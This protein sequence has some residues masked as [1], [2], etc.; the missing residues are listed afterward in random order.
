MREFST[1]ALAPATE[2]EP[3]AA[4]PHRWAAI[5]PE[6][7]V[8]SR[9]VSGHWQPVTAAQFSAEIR[10]TA[11][12]FIAAGIQPGDRVGLWSATRYEWSVLDYALGAVGAVSIPLYETEQ[13][14]EV[15]WILA[16]A[17]SVAL[18]AE[19]S[20]WLDRLAEAGL[21]EGLRVRWSLE[22]GQ[23]SALSAL[24]RLGTAV[25]D[26]AVSDRLAARE[27]GDVATVIYTSGTT[28]RPKG[29]MLTHG[30]VAAATD[31]AVAAEAEL[32]TGPDPATLLF[33]PLAHIFARLIQ[34]GA[35]R[36]GVRLGHSRGVTGLPE[37]L[38]AFDPTF[39][40]GVPRVF[41][42]VYNTASQR[43]V[44]DG[45]GRRFARATTAAIRFSRAL[46]IGRLP[47]PLRAE[48]AAFER[49]VYPGI[50]AAFGERCRFAI[51]GGAPLGERLA[52]FYRGAGLTIL[53]GYGVSEAGGALTANTP[54]S[55]KI[56]T[57][58]RPLPGVAVRVADDGELLFA[59][60]SLF[61]GYVRGGADSPVHLGWLHTGDCGE[62]D[63]EG[64]VRVTGRL[65]ELLVTA[66]GKR[67][68]PTFLEDRLR[69]HHLI[70]QALVVGDG[71]PFVA[72][73]I[74]VDPVEYADWAASRGLPSGVERGRRMPA[75]MAEIQ[76]AVDDANSGV[77]PAESIRGFAVLG[78]TWSEETGE[79]TPSLK[80]R[81]SVILPQ[82]RDDVD[83]LYAR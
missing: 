52:H 39:V 48:H 17:G 70:A 46:D 75:L 11:K 43:A 76:A 60:P 13:T 19:R 12:G 69:A 42:K 63:D 26:D 77:S 58:G 2:W 78:Q 5:E 27:P 22:D 74:T 3:V 16:D 44:A 14:A 54:S 1:P 31:A 59:G 56:G 36:A 33:L 65:E 80:L 55:H 41:E 8:L 62:V 68:S 35:V 45:R 47:L 81:R 71:R 23:E 34:W 28:G 82:H 18:I 67:V 72:A 38:R 66:G 29:C 24:A 6:R 50:R 21:H 30:Q 73:L 20:A 40:L 7:V 57:V 32:F 49:T 51:S 61:Q 37:Q 4:D 25:P 53:E 83:D 64:F 15:A 9:T 79:L 10:A